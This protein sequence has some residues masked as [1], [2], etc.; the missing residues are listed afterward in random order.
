MSVA[1]FDFDFR[2]DFLIF[3]YSKSHAMRRAR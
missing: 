3:D 1:S 2:F